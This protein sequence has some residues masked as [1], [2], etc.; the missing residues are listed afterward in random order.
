M[1]IQVVDSANKT[2]KGTLDTVDDVID[3]TR[4]VT[5]MAK[6]GLGKERRD[7]LVDTFIQAQTQDQGNTYT[8]EF[9]AILD[10]HDAGLIV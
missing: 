5:K 4:Y 8:P 6:T 9:Q 10:Q 7:Q 1:S 3:C 2:I